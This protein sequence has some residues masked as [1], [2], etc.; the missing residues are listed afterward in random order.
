MK[1]AQ[2]GY[3]RTQKKKK[4]EKE[5]EN[6]H[7]I[8]HIQINLDS[9]FQLQQTISIFGENFQKRKS[10]SSRTEKMNM[11][12]EFFIFELV[13]VPIFSLNCNFLDQICSKRYS[14]Q[15]QKKWTSSLNFAYSNQ[16]W[17]QIST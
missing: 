3:F 9:K 12:I 11:T 14:G 17:Y 5:K 2:K 15:K 10:F 7:Q 16:S 1:L 8:L 13:Y 6:H 4:K